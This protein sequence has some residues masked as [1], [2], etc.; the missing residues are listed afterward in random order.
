MVE[1]NTRLEYRVGS[2]DTTNG[3]DEADRPWILNTARNSD[4]FD[5]V[6]DVFNNVSPSTTKNA[7]IGITVT[8]LENS[9]D[10]I[11]VEL[12]R[13]GPTGDGKGFLSA[14]S[15]AVAG[16]EVTPL[17]LPTSHA[18]VTTGS[19][20]LNFNPVAQIFTAYYDVDG[21]SNGYQ[22]VAY[23]SF[24]VGSSGGGST[25][26]SPWHLSGNMG[27][28]VSVS[29]YSEGLAVASGS[30]YA[31]NFSATTYS[32]N[33]NLSSLTMSSGTL[34]PTFASGTLS[35]IASI[36]NATSSIS[37]TPVAA[38]ANAIITVN[39]TA[40]TSGSASSGIPLDVGHNKA[41]TIEVTAQDGVTIKTYKIS[42]VRQ[43]ST[44][45][46]GYD[47]FIDNILDTSKWAGIDVVDG[48][49]A[50]S[51]TNARLEYTVGSPTSDH[52]SAQRRWTMNT[53]S[54]T[55]PF[56]VMVDVFNNLAPT[57]FVTG[58]ASTYKNAGV[59]IT[60]T[61]LENPDDN[62]YVELYRGDPSG[63][64]RGFLSALQTN[65]INAQGDHEVLPRTIPSSN[66][67]SISGSVRLSYD[68]TAKVFTAY[69][70]PDGSSNGY[71]W[72][73]YG[74]FGVAG[75]G[76]STRNGT[77]QLTQNLGFQVSV[78]GFSEG[79][80]VAS[81]S[82]YA[83]NISTFTNNYTVTSVNVGKS[84]GYLQTSASNVIVDPTAGSA[85]YGGPYG[86]SVNVEGQNISTLGS[87]PVVTG[88]FTAYHLN[89]ASTTHNEGRLLYSV[90]DAMWRY[91]SPYANDWGSPTLSDLDARFSSGTYI[92]TVGAI[93]VPLVLS[94]DIYPNIPTLTLSGGL[95]FG[96][97]YYLNP[98]AALTITTNAYTGY[99]T[100]VED[101][102]QSGIEGIVEHDVFASTS[103]GANTMSY[104]VAAN[105]LTLGQTYNGWASFSAVSNLNSA[106]LAGSLNAAYYEKGTGFTLVAMTLQ[107]SWRQTYFGSTSNAGNA[108]DSSDPDHDGMTNLLEWACNLDP[109]TT[110][111]L[112]AAGVRNGTNL[113]FTYTRSLG[114]M[115]AGTTFTVEWSDTLVGTSWSNTGVTEQILSDDG[116]V[117]QV[118]ALVPVAGK[119]RCFVHLKVTAPP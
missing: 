74:S 109:T 110:S 21:S 100:H 38:Q 66:P 37:V 119:G 102:V 111:K 73:V 1:S 13:S 79:L 67:S 69:Y 52:D 91:G 54:N 85:D 82:V 43:S 50:L 56:E 18:T 51:E 90:P 4:A 65:V 41:I 27:F 33:A 46:G 31:D 59:G 62:I 26:N 55:L 95:W 17:T 12:F 78:G 64:G 76:G 72:Q 99:G 15:S 107:Q 20:R 70:D 57:G 115:T 75:S 103:P 116:T 77:W 117:Q 5:L 28:Q 19:V 44:A 61:S 80:T 14:L 92:I 10:S 60:V 106:S 98:T 114:A 104:Q 53:A 34:T 3:F 96:G 112:P 88:P 30:V 22:W 9:S 2:P 87:P 35:Y 40:V 48:G 105:T 118:R 101:A 113:E 94:G 63:D 16:G 24:G 32:S 89:N 108:A 97:K 39:G 42:P 83:D 11:F 25:R 81:G 86:F 23:G 84:I 7:S 8:S 68:S 58:S 71:Q 45:L 6:L 49:A 47:D 36:N 93:S 29:G